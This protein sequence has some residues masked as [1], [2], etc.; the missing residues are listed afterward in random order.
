MSADPNGNEML[1][2]GG[3]NPR[4][5]SQLSCLARVVV[6]QIICEFWVSLQNEGISVRIRC[7]NHLSI[8]LR[9][10][11]DVI[12]WDR[13]FSIF[14]RSPICDLEVKFFVNRRRGF[15]GRINHKVCRWIWIF[16]NCVK[17]KWNKKTQSHR[18]DPVFYSPQWKWAHVINLII[19]QKTKPDCAAF[20]LLR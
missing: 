3:L 11:I 12:Q 13:A 19:R 10:W 20:D 7:L 5:H 14:A 15:A 17:L 4:Q 9:W 16:A 6:W 18:I 1:F 8:H 2:P